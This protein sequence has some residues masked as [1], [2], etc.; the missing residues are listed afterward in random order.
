MKSADVISQVSKQIE[1]ELARTLQAPAK[2]SLTVEIN[3]GTG[4][5]VGS[6]RLKTFTEEEM[7]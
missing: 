4:G 6:I 2:F 5:V 7:R 1:R 3:R